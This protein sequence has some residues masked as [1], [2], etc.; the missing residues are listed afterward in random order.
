M[1]YRSRHY[2]QVV[3]FTLRQ[4]FPRVKSP[5]RLDGSKSQFGHSGNDRKKSLPSAGYQTY[6]TQPAESQ[7]TKLSRL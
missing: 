2:K 5:M 4:N 7:F 1:H 6:V 3:C